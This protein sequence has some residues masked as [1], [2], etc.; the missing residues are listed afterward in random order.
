MTKMA[1]LREKKELVIKKVL[2]ILIEMYDTTT[3][4][5][6]ETKYLSTMEIINLIG[7]LKSHEERVLKREKN[8]SK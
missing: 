3:L 6:E 1:T 5:I 7:S 8:S 4:I 2:R